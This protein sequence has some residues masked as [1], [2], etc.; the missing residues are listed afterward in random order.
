MANVTAVFWDIGG[1]ILSNGWD[2]AARGKA[3]RRFGLD[4]ED[5]EQRHKQASP[6]LETGQTTLDTY[7]E[8]TVF[9]CKRSF[10]KE[11]FTAFIFQQS[12]E[13]PESR[14][15][16]ASVAQTQ[17]YFLAAINNES[18]EV[19]A[20]R[21]EKF[22]LR[23]ELP[24]FFSSCYMGVRKPDEKIFRMALE[25]T[26]RR[27]EESL[28]IDDREVD[29]EAP[30]RLGMR[31]IHFQNATQLRRDLEA[32]GIIAGENRRAAWKSE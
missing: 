6:A 18:R 25:I 31:T 22:C 19:N 16:L 21:I 30:Q 15:V 27:P 12:V 17:K 9:Y 28:F 11:E 20:F 14:A 7:L 13:L 3:V 23:R 29:L 24:L 26:Q 1:V 32:S 10:A 5:F 2:S 4:A 8:R